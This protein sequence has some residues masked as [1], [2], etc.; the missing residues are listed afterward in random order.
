[1]HPTPPRQLLCSTSL[2]SVHVITDVHL[3]L[4]VLRDRDNDKSPTL[5]AL[6][7]TLDLCQVNLATDQHCLPCKADATGLTVG[8][9]SSAPCHLEEITKHFSVFKSRVNIVVVVV[10]L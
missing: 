1:M 7:L 8:E 4:R 5:Q 9:L 2:C 3:S 6:D 10:G